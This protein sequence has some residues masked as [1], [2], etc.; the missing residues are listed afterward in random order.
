MESTARLYQCMFCH[1]QVTICRKCDRGNIYC[2]GDCA[3]QARTIS[4]KLAKVRYQATFIGKR[5]NAARQ[6]RFR[7]NH[8]KIVTYHTSPPSP[9]HDSIESLEKKPEKTENDHKIAALTCCFCN[10]PVS[11]WLRNDFLRRR[12]HKQS[13]GSQAFPHAP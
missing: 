1:K 5:H 4:L 2:A 10:K 11:C 12:V 8:K 13:T 3:V 9:Q 6:A 7:K